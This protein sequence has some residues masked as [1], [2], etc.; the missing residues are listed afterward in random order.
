MIASTAG[1]ALFYQVSN[2]PSGRRAHT[3]GERLK[4]SGMRRVE[5]GT[6][7]VGALRALYVTGG[8]LWDGF[9]AQPYRPA[10]E[11]TQVK[12]TYPSAVRG[13]RSARQGVEAYV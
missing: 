8:Q 10:A 11:V 3:D 5:E 13:G 12:D 4:G 1:H 9:W 2:R 6:A 7:A